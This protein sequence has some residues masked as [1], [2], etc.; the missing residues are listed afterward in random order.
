MNRT[1]SMLDSEVITSTMRSIQ[2]D[3]LSPMKSLHDKLSPL[4]PLSSPFRVTSPKQLAS[5]PA[6]TRPSEETEQD[7][8][9]FKKDT[10]K[11]VLSPN[12]MLTL[13]GVL[14]TLP[15]L[16]NLPNLPHRPNLPNLPTVPTF[17]LQKKVIE[18]NSGMTSYLKPIFE[19]M[20]P[21]IQKHVEMKPILF[22]KVSE[23]DVSP[24]LYHLISHFNSLFE[25]YE[26]F[27]SVWEGRKFLL[28]D[29]L[30]PVAG[31]KTV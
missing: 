20:K 7:D 31:K 25:A 17:N 14:E 9:E 3:M 23:F 30:V 13:T 22:E 5:P 6:R 1:N 11:E 19:A 16:P 26:V 24:N 8:S 15:T 4:F 27:S 21:I 12:T 2:Q 28:R 29:A 18:E 10:Q